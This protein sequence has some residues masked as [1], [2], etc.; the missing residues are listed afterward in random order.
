M[1][2]QQTL[3]LRVEGSSP[4]RLTGIPASLLMIGALL[5]SPGIVGCVYLQERVHGVERIGPVSV[6]PDS[7][8]VLRVL[9]S[10]SEIERVRPPMFATDTFESWLYE[11]RGFS[12][13]MGWRLANGRRSFF[14]TKNTSITR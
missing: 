12:V 7:A 4:S 6:R 1:A 5:A 14:Q 10:F 3:N 11:G 13:Q 8:C 9:R 2:E